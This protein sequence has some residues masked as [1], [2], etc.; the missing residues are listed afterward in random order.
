MKNL[1]L[2]LGVCVSVVCVAQI[3]KEQLALTINKADETNN[4]K[5]KEYVWKRKSDVSINGQVK[6]TTITEFSF[7]DQGKLQA[8]L[9]DAE[10]SVKQKRGVR[11]RVQQGAAED[12][13][14]YAQ[15]ALEL[16][17]AYT[18]M[19]KGQL[20]DFFSKATVTEKDGV[21]E[22]VGENVYVQG[23][24]LTLH[25]DV[26]TNLYLDRKFSSL[27][28]KD[29]IDGEINYEKFSSGTNHVSTTVLNMPAQKMKIDAKNQDYTQR[30][31]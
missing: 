25:V 5:L 14:E 19:T 31:K 3:D 16:A 24:K 26:K 17:L 28:G 18:F 23:D 13:A 15:K 7:D 1:L 27:V 12:K 10:S 4:E 21:F 22:A 2:L 9:V 20:L 30:V 6:L 8:K 11:G 29:A